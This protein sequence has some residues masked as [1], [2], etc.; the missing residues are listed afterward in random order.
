MSVSN[1]EHTRGPLVC[2][3][4]P[5]LCAPG[6]IKPGLSRLLPG[7][8]AIARARNRLEAFAGC[9]I[10]PQ[11]RRAR[12]YS[13]QDRRQGCKAPTEGSG[14]MPV[15]RGTESCIWGRKTN[16]AASSCLLLCPAPD[17]SSRTRTHTDPSPGGR[18]RMRSTFSFRRLKTLLANSQ[19][20]RDPAGAERTALPAQSGSDPAPVQSAGSW[21]L[22]SGKAGGGPSTTSCSV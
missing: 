5:L 13:S 21:L 12:P 2:A 3:M 6:P 1:I 8:W 4:H 22:T 9:L 15:T 16:Q 10:H 14:V 11:L 18:G 7:L 20:L 19:E 17:N